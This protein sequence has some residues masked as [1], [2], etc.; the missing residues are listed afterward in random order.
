M[1]SL[2]INRPKELEELKNKKQ[3]R[4]L[5]LKLNMLPLCKL[6]L[7]SFALS[8]SEPLLLN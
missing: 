4:A 8:L 5:I 1:A 6:G 7:S 3:Q 2:L